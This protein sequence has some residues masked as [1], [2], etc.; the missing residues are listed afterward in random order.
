MH[1][2]NNLSILKGSNYVQTQVK[3]KKRIEH[4]KYLFYVPVS[5]VC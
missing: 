1:Q 3:S 2:I 4:D 5:K